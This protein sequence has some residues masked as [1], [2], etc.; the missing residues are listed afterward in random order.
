MHS[1][2]WKSGR[3][4]N[5]WIVLAELNCTAAVIEHSGLALAE[6]IESSVASGEKRSV[7]WKS[8]SIYLPWFIGTRYGFT[9]A[10]QHISLSAGVG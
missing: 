8:F 9:F 3:D 6:T 7:T 4:S 5:I 1:L 2:Y 10:E